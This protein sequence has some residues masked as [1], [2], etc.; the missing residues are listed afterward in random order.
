MLLK[1]ENLDFSYPG[2]KLF[3]G[4][5]F[6]VNGKEHVVFRGESG[7][8]KSTLFKLILGFETPD[9]GQLLYRGQPLTG[10]HVKTL[11]Q[12]TA[13]LPQDLNLGEGTVKEVMDF[14]FSFT[15]RGNSVPDHDTRIET[16]MDLG[17]DSDS[18]TK[19]YSDLSTGQRQRVGL[20]LC[21]LLDKPILMLDEP[22]SALDET[23]KELVWKK[24]QS[25]E[26]KTIL[27][28]SHDPWW[29]ERCDRTI[30]LEVVE[31]E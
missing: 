27:S 3:S 5:S 4:F 31:A 19:E 30:D 11:R 8:G 10:D 14:P 16:L 6:E 26:P 29:V 20:A 24:L 25:L 22:T 18:Y 21:L 23:S 13:W 17:L 1:C 15:S 7:S 28:T 2:E 9:S 12:D